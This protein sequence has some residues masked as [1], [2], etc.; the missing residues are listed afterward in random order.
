MTG[1]RRNETE[2]TA[3]TFQ[4]GDLVLSEEGHIVLITGLGITD[5]DFA[6]VLLTKDPQNEWKTGY[7]VKTW[8]KSR[9]KI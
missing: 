9:S 1:Y 5:Q 7:Y 2:K 6:G 3:P 4:Q 8:M